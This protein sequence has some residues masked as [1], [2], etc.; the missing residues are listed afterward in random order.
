[1]L[2][3]R[4]RR[5][6][7]HIDDPHFDAATTVRS[8]HDVARSNALFGGR[9][10][11]LRAVDDALP[12]LSPAATLLDVGTGIG[13]IPF[14]ARRRASRRGIALETIGIELS[15]PLAAA[16]RTRIG[17]AVCGDGFAL[18]FG[19]RSVDVV[20]CSQVLHHFE[21]PEAARLLREMDRVA[22]V[23]V[24]VA[25]LRRSWLAAGLFWCA[26]WP[27]G[28]HPVSRHDGVVSVLR[29]FTAAELRALARASAGADAAVRHRLGWRVVAS[30]RP[31]AP[32]RMSAAAG[33]PPSAAPRA[34]SALTSALPPSP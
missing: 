1:L 18:P 11:V 8:L 14:H 29:G 7:E 2:T 23:R 20:T 4:R 9:R 13:D 12:E 21:A 6:T 27:L 31:G 26:S 3:P 24:V 22:R 19:D 17:H 30:W 28:F 16:C 25:D 32:G 34:T 15:A 10:A 5:G 33:E